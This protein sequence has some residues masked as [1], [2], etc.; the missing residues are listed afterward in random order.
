M[1]PRAF[2]LGQAGN[3]WIGA[4]T[5]VELAHEA[6]FVLLAPFAFSARA[7]RIF[8][9]AR[10]RAREQPHTENPGVAPP[11]PGRVVAV[12]SWRAYDKTFFFIAMQHN[13]CRI[14]QWSGQRHI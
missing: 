6:T 3:R 4:L 5:V 1:G 11:S 10:W 12:S 9:V 7:A 2:D 8:C 14:A 13:V